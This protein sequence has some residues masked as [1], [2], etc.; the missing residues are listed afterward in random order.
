MIKK[1]SRK[2]KIISLHCNKMG[3]VNA[4]SYIT[5]RLYKKN[6]LLSAKIK[7]TKLV[8]YLRNNPY[9]TQ[10]FTQIF[11]RDELDIIFK[12]DPEF[13]IDG[14]ANIG[15]ATLYLK[16]KYPKAKIIAVEPERSNFELLKK[17]TKDYPEISCLNYGIWNKTC[18][19][20]IIDKGDGNASFITKELSE[21]ETG[22]N[23][24]N[25]ITIGDIVNQFKIESL[26]VLKLD[27][28]GSEREVFMK[29]YEGWLKKT[30]N[31]IV[32][33]HPHLHADAETIITSALSEDF[34]ENPAGEYHFFYRKNNTNNK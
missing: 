32:E 12:K 34:I 10:V 14:G 3:Y 18:R 9:D 5:Q 16:N 27:I 28:E 15:L 20:Q 6:K 17:N 30:Q 19:L 11:M 33:I 24:I 1:L 8:I 13:I 22:E 25:A 31:I 7:N 23:V 2:L 29:N 26:D 4:S 21:N